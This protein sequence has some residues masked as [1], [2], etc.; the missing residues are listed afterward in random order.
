MH[1]IFKFILINILY[2]F[3]MDQLFILRRQFTV[4]AVYPIAILVPFHSSTLRV[5][6][7]CLFSCATL[8]FLMSDGQRGCA[9]NTI[10]TIDCKYSKLP[11]E[12]ELFICSKYVEDILLLLLTA[13]SAQSRAMTS[14]FLRFL[15]HTQRR[16]TIGRTSLDE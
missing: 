11:P 2:M 1:F 13:L 5:V 6:T 10:N 4:H 14:S 16:I 7:G 3:R 8:N 12:D 9:I 15:D